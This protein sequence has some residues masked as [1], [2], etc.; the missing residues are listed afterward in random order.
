MSRSMKKQGF[1]FISFPLVHLPSLHEWRTIFCL[2]FS[3]SDSIGNGKSLR[4][5]ELVQDNT[6]VAA[7]VKGNYHTRL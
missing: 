4:K 3:Q 6:S 2:T 5:A 1:I 7:T